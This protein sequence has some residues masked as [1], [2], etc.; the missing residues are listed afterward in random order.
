MRRLGFGL[1]VAVVGG[2]GPSV[3]LDDAADTGSTT[4]DS[5]DPS[6]GPTTSMGTSAGTT[7]V[8]SAGTTMGMSV[9]TTEDPTNGVTTEIDDSAGCGA[10]IG[11]YDAGGDGGGCDVWAQD[12]P[13][14]ERCMP[15]ANDGGIHWNSVRCSPDAPSADIGDP[16]TVEGSAVSSFDNCPLGSMC[17][18]VEPSTNLGTCVA[19]CSGS[20]ADPVCA[21]P[22]DVCQIAFD[23][24][25]INCLPTCNPLLQ[26]CGQG[27]CYHD[28]AGTFACGPTIGNG[29]LPGEP[30]GAPWD[31]LPGSTCIDGDVLF[32]C[33]GEDCCTSFCDLDAPSCTDGSVCTPWHDE[34]Q[35]PPGLELVGLCVA[36]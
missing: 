6:A 33:D 2:C 8:T 22:N 19:N 5:A 29:L 20:E 4:G 25:M 32:D 14:G 26:N 35:A 9:G 13:D 1:L 36:G 16:C 31:C 12:C 28:D 15:W 17:L 10:F 18:F 7:A 21:D 30:C 3:M 24:V 11:C 27:G 23:G 34:G